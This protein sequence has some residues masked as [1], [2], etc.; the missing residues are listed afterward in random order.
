MAALAGLLTLGGAGV[1]PAKALGGVSP[2]DRADAHAFV[3]AAHRFQS[4]L[5]SLRG[6]LPGKNPPQA[7]PDVWTAI[8]KTQAYSAVALAPEGRL[9]HLEQVAHSDL[10]RFARDLSKVRPRQ[11]ALAAYAARLQAVTQALGPLARA[12]PIDEC[13][14]V[15]DWADRGYSNYDPVIARAGSTSAVRSAFWFPLAGFPSDQLLT[16]KL[17]KALRAAGIGA[18]DARGVTVKGALDAVFGRVIW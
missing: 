4:A 11:A 16:T 12:A 1:S 17:V 9:G 6:E 15:S 3:S 7:C 13:I 5:R 14:A 18:A 10:A 2:H 8:P